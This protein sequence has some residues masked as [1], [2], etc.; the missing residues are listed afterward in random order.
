MNKVILKNN[1]IGFM[2]SGLGGLSVLREAIR[3]MP[4]EDFVYFGDSKNAP[5]GTKSTDEIVSLTFRAVETLMSYNPKALVIACNTATGAAIGLLREKYKGIP[6]IGIE[7]AIKPAVICSQGG[8]IIVMATPMT[9]KQKKFLDLLDTYKYEAEIIPV[10]CP[11][12]M[13]FVEEGNFN[14]AVLNEYFDVHLKASLTDNTESIV[15][16]CTHYPFLKKQIEN[17]LEN[18]KINLIDGSKGTSSELKRQ[19]EYKDWLRKDNHIGEIKILNSS[20]DE[21]LIHLSKN[22]IKLS[23]E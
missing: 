22:L 1:P 21:G 3:L 6:I 16:G 2:D 18:K 7:P 15:L 11:G 23:M 13:E 12:L 17:Y 4:K 8:R 10:P 20:K 19:L 9:I 5:Y 14:Q